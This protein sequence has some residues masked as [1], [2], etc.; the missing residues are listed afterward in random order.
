MSGRTVITYIRDLGL[1]ALGIYMAMSETGV[2]PFDRPSGGPNVWVL[3]FAGLLC[4]GPV[5]LQALS[6]RFG[7][8]PSSR[9][10]QQATLPEPSPEPSPGGD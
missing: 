7:S 4:N 10:D 6:I 3:I 1:Y 8:G 9:P 2:P 5:V